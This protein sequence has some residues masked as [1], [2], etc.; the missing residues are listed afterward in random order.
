MRW[1]AAS[2]AFVEACRARGEVVSVLESTFEEAASS[3]GAWDAATFAKDLHE[4][5]A[6]WGKVAAN[7][8]FERQ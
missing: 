5:S 6:Y 7:T 3:S 4:R 8:A 2:R 1:D